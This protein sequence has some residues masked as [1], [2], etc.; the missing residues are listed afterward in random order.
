MNRPFYVACALA[1]V[2]FFAGPLSAEVLL[3]D[4]FEGEVPGENLK[5]NCVVSSTAPATITAVSGSSTGGQGTNAVMAEVKDIGADAGTP[6]WVITYRFEPQ[7]GKV[8]R[9]SYKLRVNGE[10]ECWFRGSLATPGSEP[11]SYFSV[12][13][14]QGKLASGFSHHYDGRFVTAHAALQKGVWYQVQED[15]NLANQTVSWT[16]ADL[17]GAAMSP[18]AAGEAPLYQPAAAQ[19]VDRLVFCAVEH[20]GSFNLDDIKIETL[21]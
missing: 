19:T 18:V 21:P 5:L 4:S 12:R 7:E 9:V 6:P 2:C 17:D 8:I 1:V 10:G 15:I 11:V 16:I 3:E 13:G 14:S 20:G